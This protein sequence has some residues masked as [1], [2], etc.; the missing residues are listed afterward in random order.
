[1]QD[2]DRWL[3]SIRTG[4]VKVTH[5]T[6]LQNWTERFKQPSSFFE[7]LIVSRISIFEFDWTT[8]PTN[9]HYEVIICN[10][11]FCSFVAQILDL[12]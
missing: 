8:A 10:I 1:M 11:L 5:G 2:I 12:D 7:L 9:H 4:G 6:S 3:K